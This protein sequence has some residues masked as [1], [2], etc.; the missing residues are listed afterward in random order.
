MKKKTNITKLHYVISMLIFLAGLGIGYTVNNLIQYNHAS[1][2]EIEQAKNEIA[3]LYEGKIV[4]SCAQVNTGEDNASEKYELTYRNLRVN[5]YANRAIISDCSDMD[6]LLYKNKSGEW[7][8]SSVNLQIGNR[9]SP[10]W[11]K[12]CGIEGITVADDMIRPENSSID[13]MN[14]EECKQINQQ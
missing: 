2:Q 7:L 11:Q 9:A 1:A 6:T 4:D 12:E 3:K 10:D 14:L 8:Q 5:A 13:E